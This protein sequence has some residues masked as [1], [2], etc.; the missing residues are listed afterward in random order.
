MSRAMRGVVFL[1]S[2]MV[3]AA[4]VWQ[5]TSRRT[6]PEVPA[7]PS[8]STGVMWVERS[9]EWAASSVQAYRLAGAHVESAAQGRA[10]RSWAVIL[11]A[12]ETVISNVVYQIERELAGLPFTQDSWTAWVRRREATPMPG[13]AAFLDRVQALGGVIAIVTNRLGS[14]CADTEAVFRQHQLPFDAMLCRPDGT[15]SDKNP[16]FAAVA[17]GQ[18]DGAPGPL[19]IVAV[20]GDNI[21]DFPGQ[22]QQL[23]AEGEAAFGDFGRRYFV[24]PNPMYGSWQPR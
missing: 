6:A 1:G 21:H 5:F 10:A 20:L 22:G 7:A 11:D 12:D 18:F 19:E 17:A 23:R 2:L 3:V 14:E 9:A 4:L 24:L 13:S 15:P 16:R 8:I